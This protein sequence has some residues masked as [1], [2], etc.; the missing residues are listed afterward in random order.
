MDTTTHQILPNKVPHLNQYNT[1]SETVLHDEIQQKVHVLNSTA[2][3]IWEHCDGKSSFDALIDIMQSKFKDTSRETLEQDIRKTL[4]EFH[5]K[6][7]VSP[8]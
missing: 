5:Q 6:G 8:L 1:G 3:Y 2:L 7:L 4:N